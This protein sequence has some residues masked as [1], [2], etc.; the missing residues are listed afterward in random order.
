MLHTC[1]AAPGRQ[2]G[3]TKGILHCHLTS[4]HSNKA[5]TI[6]SSSMRCQITEKQLKSC[7]SRKALKWN[8]SFIFPLGLLK[9]MTLSQMSYFTVS[10]WGK[11]SSF[12]QTIELKQSS[13]V[14]TTGRVVLSDLGVAPVDL[15]ISLQVS[16]STPVGWIELECGLS[17]A[18][19]E[20]DVC[21]GPPLAAAEF[22]VRWDGYKARRM[23]FPDAAQFS[24]I[25]LHYKWKKY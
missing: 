11:K 16:A 1:N 3:E 24:K 4:G 22:E 2:N 15:V 12:G 20:R 13:R 6:L 23:W 7:L 19:S 5:I 8:R 10:K 17:E 21:R 14:V 9:K 18:Y 25:V